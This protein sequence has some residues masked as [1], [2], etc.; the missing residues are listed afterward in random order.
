MQANRTTF[1]ELDFSVYA[2]VLA[3]SNHASYLH[4][5]Q[6][7]ALI[8]HGRRL[9]EAAVR[10]EDEQPAVDVASGVLEEW[11]RGILALKEMPLMGETYGALF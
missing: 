11:T 9:F 10:F 8:T 6:E 5:Q 4:L 2:D 7:H 3:R 1:P